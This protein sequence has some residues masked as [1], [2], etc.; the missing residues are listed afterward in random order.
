MEHFSHYISLFRIVFW[1]FL[2]ESEEL[3]SP[4]FH[5]HMDYEKLKLLIN[6]RHIIFIKQNDS[7]NLHHF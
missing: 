6:S 3:L 5:S 7:L 4:T 2:Q 1:G